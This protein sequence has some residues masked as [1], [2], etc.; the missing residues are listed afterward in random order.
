M[1]DEQYGVSVQVAIPSR[2]YSELPIMRLTGRCACGA[3]A[4]EHVVVEQTAM[5]ER[6]W[7]YVLRCPNGKRSTP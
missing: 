7:S 6:G 2:I 3:Q 5:A 1:S 4:D